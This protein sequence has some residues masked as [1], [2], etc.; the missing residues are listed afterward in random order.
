MARDWLVGPGGER[1]AATANGQQ[2]F[3]G[4]VCWNGNCYPPDLAEQAFFRAHGHIPPA[5][6]FSACTG[7]PPVISGDSRD[8]CYRLL[9]LLRLCSPT[10]VPRPTGTLPP[11]TPIPRSAI[12]RSAIP[13]SAIPR[14]AI[15]RSAILRAAASPDLSRHIHQD[16]NSA[17]TL[18]GPSRSK[19]QQYRV[20]AQ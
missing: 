5:F 7:I 11:P 15:P 12:P 13:R 8:P 9:R 10:P 2:H 18:T 3:A 17:E 14:S 6:A 20:Q 16:R 4:A 1:L 19:F